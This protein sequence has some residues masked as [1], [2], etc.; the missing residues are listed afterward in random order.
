MKNKTQVR[1][2]M[3]FHRQALVDASSTIEWILTY[4]KMDHTIIGHLDEYVD[5]VNRN[6][7]HI[8]TLMGVLEEYPADGS[9][10]RLIL[11][12]LKGR[13]IE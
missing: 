1:K 11:P 13:K 9:G 8:I 6:W 10:D 12:A 4:K 3:V 7:Q 2:M 5:K